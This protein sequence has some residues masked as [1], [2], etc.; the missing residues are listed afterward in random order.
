MRAGQADRNPWSRYG[1]VVWAAWLVFLVFPVLESLA[2]DTALRR[3]I[4]L[5]GT[6]VFG[7][8][9]IGSLLGD[10]LASDPTAHRRRQ[11]AAL[12]LLTLIAG[13]EAA[14]I[15]LGAISFLPFLM[16]FGMFALPRP[17][18]WWFACVVTGVLAVPWVLDPDEGWI[19][20]SFVVVAVALGT[21]AGRLM[22]DQGEDWSR[23]QEQ[24]AITAERDRVARDVHDV[25]GHSLTVVTVKAQLAER[26]V[27]ADP[28]RAKAELAEVQ[29]LARQALAEIRTTVRGLRSTALEDELLAAADALDAAGISAS[30]P[31]DPDVLDPRHR[32]VAAW[33]VR[34]AVTNVVRHSGARRCEVDV[35]ADRLSVRDDGRGRADGGE[36]GGLRGLRERVAASGGA[37][38]IVPGRDGG[39]ELEVTW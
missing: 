20:V 9:Y 36:G 4:G 29:L 10:G 24:L 7:L 38:T 27:D 26:L 3:T 22:A 5:V 6:A 19:F 35:A 15:G 12:G 13:V 8:V 16:A 32:T 39:T 23:V 2:A 31:E 37:L 11:V 1:W 17:A 28:E 21:G 30:L 14:A 18:N 25:L 33:A 34:E